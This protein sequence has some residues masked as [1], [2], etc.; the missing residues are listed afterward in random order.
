MTKII[1]AI[2]TIFLI[3]CSEKQYFKPQTIAGKIEIKDKLEDSIYQANKNGAMLENGT[4][5]TKDGIYDIKLKENFSFLNTSGDLLLVADYTSN[6]L[7]IL[8]KDGKELNSFKFEFMP[9][10][11]SLRDN[12][13]AVVL[14]DNTSILWDTNTNE[15]LFSHKSSIVYT[16]NSK[17]ASPLFLDTMI[18]FPTLDGRLIVVSL[19]NF[20]IIRNVT[21]G[22]G[23]YFSNIIY[24]ALGENA[25]NASALNNPNLI[26]A[27]N[28]KLV[29]IVGGKEFNYSANINDIL[30]TNNKIYI[31]SLEGEVIELDLLLNELNKK[32]F[33]FATL[34]GIIISDSIYTLESQGYLIK[35]EP[36]GF[37]DSIY[38]INI[39]EY[40]NSFYTNDVIYYDNQ[41]IRIPK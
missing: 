16:I 12:I 2:L 19:N 35:I 4:L 11:A 7:F 5:I 21:I 8:N 25:N 37:I 24:L 14:A 34:S 10:S 36:N 20:K 39:D 22:S 41:I 26:V 23:S 32:K 9:V 40:K 18:I 27:T 31:L 3:G 6:T 33:Q 30:Y 29:S 15:G 38:K 28:N 1:F 13:L 17:S